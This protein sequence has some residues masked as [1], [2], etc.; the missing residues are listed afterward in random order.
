MGIVRRL[1]HPL[2]GSVFVTSG[3]ETLLDLG[4][5]VQQA[6]EAGF[7]QLPYGDAATV[8]RASAAAQILGGVMLVTNRAPRLGALLLAATVVPSTYTGH[9]FWTETDKQAR[10]QQRSHF[11]K[12]IGLLGGLLA[13]AAERKKRSR[14]SKRSLPLTH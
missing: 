11:A 4:P 2:L 14:R 8:V 5:R 12:N 7:D 1:A 10:A 6:R 13:T 3:V 9:P